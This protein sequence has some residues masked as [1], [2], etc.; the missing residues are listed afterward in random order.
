MKERKKFVV[1][2]FS[3]PQEKDPIVHELSVIAARERKSSSEIIVDL[4]EAFVKA[5]SSGNDSFKLDNWQEDPEF[6][7]APTIFSDPQKW[8]KYLSD[9]TPEERTKILKQANIIR[10]NAISIG[11]LRK[12]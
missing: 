10:N 6:Q 4:V 11:N 5:H 7:A 3:Y 12:K 2:S 9:C 1:T 8:F